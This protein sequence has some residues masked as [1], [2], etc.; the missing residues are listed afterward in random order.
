MITYSDANWA[1]CPDNRCSIFGYCIF[2]GDILV[3]WSSKQQT[4]ISKS[5]AEVEYR[6]NAHV[7]VETC[8]LRQLIQELYQP[9]SKAIIIYCDNDS[10]VYLLSNPVQHRSMKHIELGLHFVCEKVTLGEI[11]A[12]HVPSSS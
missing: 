3:F 9:L 1:V 12:L 10:A 7:V 6:A 4:S 11:N 5:I 8:W 2:F